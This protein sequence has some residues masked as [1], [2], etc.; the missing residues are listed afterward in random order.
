MSYLGQL[1]L[2][3]TILFSGTV[4]SIGTGTSID[5]TGFNSVSI[6]VTN[7]ANTSTTATTLFSGVI[8]IEGSN[9]NINFLPQLFLRL[10]DRYLIEQIVGVGNYII[11]T[12][13]RYI[14][15][16]VQNI[17]NS[18]SIVMLGSSS[19]APSAADLINLA[20]DGSNSVPLNVTLQPGNPGI[21]LDVQNALVTSDAPQA[22][23]T[24]PLAINETYIIDTTGYNSITITTQALAATGGVQG[25]NDGV[26]FSTIVGYNIGTSLTVNTLVAISNYSFPCL[27]RYLKIV[28]TTAGS[29]TY[30]LRSQPFTNINVNVQ[31][32]GG[33]AVSAAS[34]QLGMNIANYGG[35]AV[36]TGG[37]AGIPS[38]G[39]N[40]AVGTAPTANP[41]PL[42][43]DT[44]GLT[45]RILLDSSGKIAVG[46][47]TIPQTTS[48]G[49][50]VSLASA[51][52]QVP[53][54]TQ[55]TSQFEWQF[56]DEILGQILLELKILNQQ[57]FELPRIQ[58]NAFN[59]A[60]YP[61][62]IQTAPILG[63]EPALFRA[64]PSLFD[65][66]Q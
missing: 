31:Q 46:N 25:S 44:S 50:P 63:D 22:T 11:D 10:E 29:F 41:I 4:N 39:G 27:T 28:A 48:T 33:S 61:V 52:N 40:I 58:M 8:N 54:N 24:P 47:I 17:T 42:A 55:D 7:L 49:A 5:T 56:R 38:V 32:I 57:I 15:Y 66:Q 2:D 12:N 16:N 23:Q 21:K 37:V 51:Q 18:V 36:V 26:T 3:N 45:R 60:S 53:L 19:A 20:L 34:A 30:Y 59:G 43:V 62:A 65:K 6:Q 35:T 14:R 9:D 13:T 1:Y 64:E